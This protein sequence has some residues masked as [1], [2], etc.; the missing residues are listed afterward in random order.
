MTILLGECKWKNSLVEDSVLRKLVERFA[1]FPYERKYFYLFSKS[2]YT[3][4][5]SA[6][7]KALGNV[8]LVEFKDM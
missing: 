2:G 1:L 5:C 6:L 3:H 4:E 7:A 8:T